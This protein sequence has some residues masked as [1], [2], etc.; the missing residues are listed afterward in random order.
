MENPNNSINDPFSL[1][2]QFGGRLFVET[3][4]PLAYSIELVSL[5]LV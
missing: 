4:F 2:R 3:S 5:G 1:G